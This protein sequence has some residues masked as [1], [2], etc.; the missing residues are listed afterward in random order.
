MKVTRMNRLVLIALCIVLTAAGARAQVTPFYSPTVDLEVE[1]GST[2]LVIQRVT[3]PT[4]LKGQPLGSRWRLELAGFGDPIALDGQ[5]ARTMASA[6]GF[7][8]VTDARKRL[9]S[10]SDR[11]GNA[12]AIAY[13]GQGRVTTITGPKNAVFTFTRDRTGRVLSIRTPRGDLAY[14]Y[15]NDDLSTVTLNGGPPIRYAYGTTVG[16][17]RV[18][19]PETGPIDV[20]YDASGRVSAYRFADGS[21]ARFEFDSRLNLQR[22]TAPDGT[23]TT[24]HL[25]AAPETTDAGGHRWRMEWDA[26][27]RTRSDIAPDGSLT[28]T[29]LGDGDRVMAIVDPI[30]RR[31][32]YEYDAAGRVTAIVHP[33]DRRQTFDYDSYGSLTAERLNGQ[34]VRSFTYHADG[35]VAS[36][37]GLDW[38]ERRYTYTPQGQISAITM[39]MGGVTTY[40]YDTRGNLIREINALKGVTQRSYDLQNRLIARLEPGG[41]EWKFRYDDRG[42][43]AETSEPATGVNR[44]EFDALNR[45]V[46]VT[47]AL[48]RSTVDYDAADRI[49]K[50]SGPGNLTETFSYDPRGHLVRS[51][52]ATGTSATIDYD[53]VGRVIRTRVDGGRES[54]NQYNPAGDLIVRAVA[55]TTAAI[56]LDPAGR[57]AAIVAAGATA[58]LQHDALGR[59][60]AITDPLG[61]TRQRAYAPDGTLLLS[62]TSRGDEIQLAHDLD[63]RR[64]SVRRAGGGTD[65]FSYDAA[66]NVVSWVAPLG[67]EQRRAYDAAG[68]LTSVQVPSGATIKL[69]WDAAGRLSERDLGNGTKHTFRYDAAG[70]LLEASDGQ[71]PVRYTRD[72]AGR[73]TQ[74]DF[75]AAQKSIRTAYDDRGRRLTVTDG[76]GRETGYQY[77]EAGQATAIRLGDGSRVAFTYDAAGRIRTLTYPNG[78]MGTFDYDQ[79]GEVSRLAYSTG[80]GQSLLAQSYSY[81][82]AGNLTERRADGNRV[83][84][85]T[86]DAGDQLVGEATG[87]ATTRFDYGAGGNRLS[88]VRDGVT[89][90][91]EYNADDRLTVAESVTPPP[92]NR[93]GATATRVRTEFVYDARGA[94]ER[95]VSGNAP[96]TFR[97]DPLDRLLE[98]RGADGA[99]TA[100]EYSADGDRLVRR[101]AT[102]VTRF[103]YDGLDLIQEID[104]QGQ[105]QAAYTFAPGIDRPIAMWK[106]GQ[107]YFFLADRDGSILAITDR[108]GRIVSNYEYDA[109]GGFRLR[110]EGV[111]SAFG[112]AGREFD[113]TTQLYYFRDR[114]YDPAIGRFLTVDAA[115]PDDDE[116][117]SF[118]PYIYA[119]NN[120]LKYTDPLGLSPNPAAPYPSNVQDFVNVKLDELGEPAYD[121]GDRHEGR[122]PQTNPDHERR[123]AAAAEKGR[124][125]QKVKS[126]WPIR[127]G[128]EWTTSRTNPQPHGNENW[129][130]APPRPPKLRPYFPPDAVTPGRGTPAPRSIADNAVTPGRGIPAPPSQPVP[131]SNAPV[132]Q[133]EPAAQ[134]PRVIKPPITVTPPTGT[135]AP[136]P[137]T[138]TAAAPPPTTVKP[139]ITVTPPI[140]T[141]VAPPPVVTPPVAAPPVVTPPVAAVNPPVTPPPG[142]GTQ[143]IAQPPV[144]PQGD[145]IRTPAQPPGAPPNTGVLTVVLTVQ[146]LARCYRDGVSFQDCVMS[147]W[148][149][150]SISAGIGAVIVVT[151]ES[152]G[153][154]VLGV[155]RVLSRATLVLAAAQVAF[156]SVD[157]YNEYVAAASAMEQADRANAAY[158][159]QMTSRVRALEPIRKSVT[160]LSNIDER[161]VLQVEKELPPIQNQLTEL[162]A[163][164]VELEQGSIACRTLNTLQA[165]LA[166][167]RI[168]VQRKYTELLNE[169]IRFRQQA[170]SCRTPQAAE[171]LRAQGQ[172][173]VTV[174]GDI[175]SLTSQARET[176]AR[177]TQMAMRLQPSADYAAANEI[178]RRLA[179]LQRALDRLLQTNYGSN[180]EYRNEQSVAD[181]RRGIQ[182]LRA[183]QAKAKADLARLSWPEWI[184]DI[185]RTSRTAIDERLVALESVINA[186]EARMAEALASTA[187]QGPSL[188][189]RETRALLEQLITRADGLARRAEEGG[190]RFTDDN[191]VM[192][193]I[194]KTQ[195]EAD[196]ARELVGT[197]TAG[198]D[199]CARGLPIPGAT[200]GDPPSPP[201]DLDANRDPPPQ[202]PPLPGILPRPPDRSDPPA[203]TTPVATPPSGTTPSGTTP[204]STTGGGF[205]PPPRVLEAVLECG[206]VLELPSGGRP[207]I[208][209]VRVRGWES[210]R[211]PVEVRILPPFTTASGLLAS[212]GDTS[213]GGDVMYAA[214]VQDRPDEYRFSEIWRALRGA[215]AGSTTIVVIVRQGASMVRLPLTLNV[216][217]PGA[218]TGSS[219]E[220]PTPNITGSGGPYCVWQYKLFGDP[221]G[222]WHLAAAGCT[223]R[224]YA[225]RP[226]YVMVGN[227]LTRGEADRRIGE[228]SRYFDDQNCKVPQ[229]KTDD[230]WGDSSRQPDPLPDPPIQPQPP[231]PPPPAPEPPP[232]PVSR[233]S[234]FGI[235]PRDSTIKVGET[236]A[237]KAYATAIGAAD[238]VLTLDE[239]EVRWSGDKPPT[240]TATAADAGR[241]FRITATG[242]AG[243]SDT[244]TIVVDRATTTAT[245]P[246]PPAPG[247]VVNA[248][249]PPGALGLIDKLIKPSRSDGQHVSTLSDTS[250]E[251][252]YVESAT[253]YR[254]ARWTFAPPPPHLKEGEPNEIAI[255][256]DVQQEPRI[257]SQSYPNVAV[258]HFNGFDVTKDSAPAQAIIINGQM[259]LTP[260][261]YKFTL[262][263]GVTKAVIAFSCDG[264]QTFATYT[265]GVK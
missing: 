47:N 65:R 258:V 73:A 203:G 155:I 97:F 86:Y 87:A 209:G 22:A 96:A 36:A 137:P 116:P 131:F 139:P 37:R 136:A 215:P 89:T 130:V 228:L 80:S 150:L 101:D 59:L 204:G 201:A 243:E 153:K 125:A 76:N 60:T 183:E 212:P 254:V 126:A 55:G 244:V 176:R 248:P 110:K 69:T 170:A 216:I 120:P 7:V 44:F 140:G 118:N 177:M 82:A 187:G 218:P 220:P 122:R 28:R 259:K 71:N 79:G 246:A 68:R 15:T 24:T 34:V 196:S 184:T 146:Q 172:R 249:A 265:Y 77:N 149:N 252:R 107:M 27:R 138:T 100:F 104:S 35:T 185:F 191:S 192:D 3:P 241:A 103:L 162:E 95:R 231:S 132:A 142:A 98:V 50:V 8:D 2:V 56:E 52:A 144:K 250:C 237:L 180:P 236:I 206:G 214:G 219:L 156:E 175:D 40:E 159:E 10:R 53:V 202:P 211:T 9:T 31:T 251:T 45:V 48:G 141:P 14:G 117:L 135:P 260:G 90:S 43:L 5:P 81:D 30:G 151:A 99:I 199:S 225:G 41:A 189:S 85:Y 49:I 72:A 179:P 121:F 227:N 255:S 207:E 242:P 157:G 169:V 233:F 166:R 163:L 193:A 160:A 17:S 105:T 54:A 6:A 129:R 152:G 165:D 262:R 16:P 32:A 247:P 133:L 200:A 88:Q 178:V 154:V 147:Y 143:P 78:V 111:T 74:V 39:A 188:R 124:A 232:G 164:V 58:R 19:D 167:R 235:A 145:T 61:R 94:L 197:V 245:G 4:M 11:R 21:T 102:G 198:A 38:P 253:N 13:D 84:R 20:S 1:T 75:T 240:F 256:A 70:R 174:A 158:L 229:Q 194:R 33:G 224:R 148:K 264:P 51:T 115:A 168:E 173:V 205:V 119:W 92:A 221:V 222:C 93:R 208:C 57:V 213:M 112:F 134:G 114:Y 223:E 109:F 230:P 181:H 239:R 23:M 91:Y 113:R 226:E 12:V 108:Q 46:A 63:G 66:G 261:K 83:T 217:P 238:M 263:P 195:F 210:S 64:T 26:V 18:D 186:E 182:A 128:K 190:C 25:G 29:T 161:Q 171:A 123:L 62:G 127:D 234:R 42:R 257:G 67:G 106:N